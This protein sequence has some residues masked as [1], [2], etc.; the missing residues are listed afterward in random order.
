MDLH[1]ALAVAILRHGFRNPGG[2][3]SI[4]E[5]PSVKLIGRD[6]A[7]DAERGFD[8]AAACEPHAP[9]GAIGVEQ[10]AF[11]IRANDNLAAL[12]AD[13]TLERGQH[14]LAPPFTIGAPATSS[15]NAITFAISPE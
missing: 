10:D 1:V 2:Q 15:A 3:R 5:Q 7:D 14:I 13:Q 11:D 6:R 9:R 4:G 8:L 12:V